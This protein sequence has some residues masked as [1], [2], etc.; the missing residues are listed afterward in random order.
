MKTRI[1]IDPGKTGSVVIQEENAAIVCH[2]MPLIQSEYDIH[3][4]KEIFTPYSFD[5][6]GMDLKV[7][8]E[9]VHA[10]FGSAAGS[11]FQF[12]FGL[13]LIEGI[14]ATYEIPYVKV[15]PKEWQ[16]LCFQGVPEMRKPATDKQKLAGKKGS[17]DTKAMALLAAKRLYPSLK[18]TFGDRAT[19]PHEG[20]VDALLMSHY[21]ITK[22]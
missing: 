20:L 22:F 9:D 17:I 15:A 14:L 3:K 7:V 2:K 10:I 11:T 4:L 1:G 12:G 18:L 21:C 6:E 5:P 8:L 16:K 13:G 19:K